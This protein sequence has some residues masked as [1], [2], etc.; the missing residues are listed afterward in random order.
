MFPPA[1]SSN[2]Q[3]NFKAQR[4]WPQ[5]AALVASND[6]RSFGSPIQTG[7]TSPAIN[8]LFTMPVGPEQFA[9]TAYSNNYFGNRIYVDNQ[10]TL[11]IVNATSSDNGYYA[12]ALI[13]SVGSV[14]AKAKLTVKQTNQLSASSDFFQDSLQTRTGGTITGKYDLSPPPV[15]K[16]GTANQTLPTNTSTTL[17]CEVVSQVAYKIQWYFDN[18][19][20]QDDPPRVTLLDTGALA[21]ENLR[22]SDS[23]IYTCVVT[24]ATM[25]NM[26]LASPFE[27]LDP[28]MLT[29]A[30]PVQ[31]S[32]SR[33]CLLR[34]ENPI[35]P[36]IPFF[37]M[38][39]SR[40]PS[41]PGQAY[42]VS[43]N[44]ND[45]ITIAWAPPADA[46]SLP[47][48]QYVV[49]HYDT[50]QEHLGWRV[51]HKPQGKESLLIDGLSPEGSHFFVIRAANSHGTGP[52]S[53]IAGPM[54]TVA[55]EARYQAELQ[56]RRNPLGSDL[57][58][59]RPD[60]SYA[61]DQ[62]MSI[63]TNLLSL[64]PVSSNSIRLQWT[65]QA[66][67]NYSEQ[68]SSPVNIP[69]N[70]GG[71]GNFIEG[72]SI[73][74]RAAGIGES[75][76]SKDPL[77]GASNPSSLPLVTSYIDE[78]EVVTNSR[79][80][81]NVLG[82]YDYSQEFNEVRVADHSTEQYTINGLRPFTIYQFFVVPYFKDIDGLPSNILSAQTNEDRP[83]VAPPNLTIRPINNT[84][85]RLLWI[86]VPP[87]YANGILRGYVVRVNRSD[88]LN[89]PSGDQSSN[90]H[91]LSMAPKSLTLP[92][93]SLVI[94]PLTAFNP[95]SKIQPHL[96]GVQQFV[97]M[98]DIADLT[99][100]SFYS[101][102]VA[103]ATSV[104]PG[105]WSESQ[106]F[107]MDHKIL[108]SQIKSTSNEYDD[109]LSK[110]LLSNIPQ[111]YENDSFS[112]GLSSIYFVSPMIMV[113]LSILLVAGFLLYRRNNQ[114]VITWKKT[115]S[116]H[117]TNKFYTPSVVDHHHHGP[118]SIQQNIYDHQ[119]HLI[120]SA[121]S[122]HMAQQS[123][124]AQT[125][126]TANNGGG[127]INSSGTGSLSSHGGLL[128]I[129]NDPNATRSRINNEQI[130]L[131]NNAKD[132]GSRFIRGT[133]PTG[134]IMNQMSTD[135][136]R[137]SNHPNNHQQIVH[138]GGDYY[139]VIN[140]A[141]EYE[142]LNQQQ[143]NAMQQPFASN[144]ER[145]QTGSSN[146]DTS[147]PSSVTRLLPNQNYNRDMLGRGY[148][149]QQ[150]HEM[151]LQQQIGCT[152]GEG[153]Q[154]FMT[155]INGNEA[156]KLHQKASL[157]PYATTN[158]M[159][160]TPQHNQH[161]FSNSPM[162]LIDSSRQ[163]NLMIHNGSTLDDS[164]RILM[165]QKMSGAQNPISSFRTLQRGPMSIQQR[166]GVAPVQNQMF[167]QHEG[168]NIHHQVGQPNYMASQ[169][170]GNNLVANITP[171][172][173]ADVK[174]NLYEHIDYGR[175]PNEINM[176]QQANIQPAQKQQVD[177]LSSSTSSGSVRSPPQH[178]PDQQS[179][180]GGN[181]FRRGSS[182]PV[183][184]AH[185]LRVFSSA[186]SARPSD[187]GSELQ[188]LSGNAKSVNNEGVNGDVAVDE[189]K[190]Q[191]DETTAFR[192]K[193]FPS[194][195]NQRNRQLSKR[196]RQQ[197]RNQMH[198]NNQKIG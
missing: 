56:R 110:S 85:I 86:H 148:V 27:P 141:T 151:V 157:S 167:V 179:N 30:P 11:N 173:I 189:D 102:Q 42:L 63:T 193:S 25:D 2:Q 117:F 155:M 67:S 36:N 177:I 175:T 79:S 115:I 126:W 101:I 176:L 145:H 87:I 39:I 54:R 107:V 121:G 13:S 164:S 3:S 158:L 120:Y 53:V 194:D 76:L 10:G 96:N 57:S 147:C 153:K 60:T 55:G 140:N 84:A 127:C 38:E 15:I 24:A 90:L 134:H 23:G 6:F 46:G 93:S 71:I 97:V 168:H 64:I 192:Q 40:Y 165:A 129:N 169:F 69:L 190:E 47:V 160:Q 119:Q 8:K 180:N 31:Q 156:S 118:N 136:T 37:R 19:P 103:A 14:M 108:A 111:T 83:S 183:N 9:Q 72:F 50:S 142:E 45:A 172:P 28:S 132:A 131:M 181:K 106:N 114:K 91:S 159:N 113:I 32:T 161:L 89:V 44:G 197:Q 124:P 104:G 73:R 184:E 137:S 196:K 116:E 99:F 122:T 109:V 130:L 150:R 163:Q 143:R 33:S 49:E 154:P 58:D 133:N 43:T 21:I 182:N 62:L 139:S 80:K 26:P 7:D 34:V 144:A 4:G 125:M 16:M 88:I 187:C 191:I 171:N 112:N 128:P 59:M 70:S 12:C 68:T 170:Q 18:K 98:Y 162:N 35:N 78:E 198:N 100:K 195:S 29:V 66:M 48:K 75:L 178:S 82:Y 95:E 166:G 186:H 185:D 77:L 92:L 105:P 61:R 20:L 149:D 17:L 152:V 22:R 188:R 174:S 138:H 65:T 52:S 81:R 51:I 123:V 135:S 94:A 41:P 1:A 74:Y 5:A 146:S